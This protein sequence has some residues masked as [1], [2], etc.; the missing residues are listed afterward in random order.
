MRR[1]AINFRAF[2]FF[3][4][5]LAVLVLACNKDDSPAPTEQEQRPEPENRAP[6]AEAGDDRQAEIGS[7]VPLD[8]SGSSDPDGDELTYKWSFVNLPEGSSAT[9]IGVG[10]DIAEFTIDKAGDFKVQLE[11]ND[12]KVTATDD[13]TISNLT[14]ELTFV[15]FF[16]ARGEENDPIAQR[17]KSISIYGDSFS[18]DRAE[19]KITLA[20]IQCQVDDLNIGNAPEDYDRIRIIVPN[21]ATSG[22]LIVSIGS[23]SVTW[24]MTISLLENPPVEAWIENDPL[25]IEK[26]RPSGTYRDIGTVFKPLVSGKLLA[27]GVR[28]FADNNEQSLPRI[29]LWDMATEQALYSIDL[30]RTYGS[31][32]WF[33]LDD[34]FQLEANKEYGVTFASNDWYSYETDPRAPFL[35]KTIGQIELVKHIQTGVFNDPITDLVF[36]DE[37]SLSSLTRGVDIL[38]LPGDE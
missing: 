31:M 37:A 10:K 15:R 36:P 26:E 1:V 29:T 8:G 6:V 18:P 2:N 17:G 14:P 27:L 4:L 3:I 7:V 13:F 24:P 12:G 20:G 23:Q 19:N 38:F 34:P 9:I 28:S 21:D 16:T 22:D 33:N 5:T 25:L 35:P 30:E 32:Q 11:V